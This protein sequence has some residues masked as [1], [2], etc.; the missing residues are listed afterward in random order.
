MRDWKSTLSLA[1][2]MGRTMLRFRR[3]SRVLRVIAE[4]PV[5]EPSSFAKCVRSSALKTC[6]FTIQYSA[7]SLRRQVARNLT[8]EHC[9]QSPFLRVALSLGERTCWRGDI[10]QLS[11]R[12]KVRIGV[13]LVL[14]STFHTKSQHIT[15]SVSNNLRPPKPMHALTS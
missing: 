1:A 13:P 7:L 12:V 15:H 10:V 5:C 14:H 3:I 2:L 9:S 11:E 6:L 8:T 4:P